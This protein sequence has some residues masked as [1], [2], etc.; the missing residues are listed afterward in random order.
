MVAEL[1]DPPT[2]VASPRSRGEKSSPVL[3]VRILRLLMKLATEEK[4]APEIAQRLLAYLDKQLAAPTDTAV[5]RL[6]AK[7]AKYQLLVALDRPQPLADQLAIWSRG[8]D[9]PA[10]WQR[11]LAYVEAELGQLA[12]AVA[13]LQPLAAADAL[14]A[15]DYRALARWHQALKQDAEYHQSLVA[16]WRQLEEW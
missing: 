7:L 3:R 6:D 1:R 4:A 11:S 8:T 14:P 13:L 12:E 15:D 9:R 10:W 2:G 16:A 5:F